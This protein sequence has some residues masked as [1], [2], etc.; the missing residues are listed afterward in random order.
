MV[1]G[2]GLGKRRATREPFGTEFWFGKEGT[3]RSGVRFVI[4]GISWCDGTLSTL[5]RI[6]EYTREDI[7]DVIA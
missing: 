6:D 2:Y 7:S 4:V 5:Y 1:E 3:V